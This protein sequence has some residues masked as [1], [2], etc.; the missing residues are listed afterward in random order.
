MIARFRRVGKE[1]ASRGLV[2]SHG[3][4]ISVRL[5]ERLL[6]TRH[7]SM[8]G[9]LGQGDLVEMALEG[10]EGIA[11]AS[12]DLEI[13]RAI[14]RI[15]AAQA[16]LHAHPPYS[17][18]LSLIQEEIEPQDVEGAYLLGKVPVVGA[19]PG[20]TTARGEPLVAQA[21]KG[22]P[23]V[24]VRGHG[25]FAIGQRLEDALHWTTALEL[26]CQVLHLL[27]GWR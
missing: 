3:G 22:S 13:H 8:L 9:S 4:N 24:V 27:R 12:L 19:G 18:A 15:T 16:I 17:L 25:S 21:I 5:G 11:L 26:S 23:I 2:S 20:S 7:G 6:I 10:Q 1:L 14:Y